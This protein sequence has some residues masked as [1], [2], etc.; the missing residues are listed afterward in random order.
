[1]HDIYSVRNGYHLLKQWEIDIEIEESYNAI[2]G[3]KLW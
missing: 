3:R 1:M 2:H